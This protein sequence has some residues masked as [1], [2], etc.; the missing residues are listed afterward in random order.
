MNYSLT[1]L[2]LLNVSFSVFHFLLTLNQK[3]F[4]PWM[5]LKF[6]TILQK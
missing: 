6:K 5:E 1:L 3:N 2:L 4:Y